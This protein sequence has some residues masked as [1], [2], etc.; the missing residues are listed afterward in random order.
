MYVCFVSVDR[1]YPKEHFK[2][3]YAVDEVQHTCDVSGKKSSDGV[4]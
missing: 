4:T 2:E 1:I 3:K